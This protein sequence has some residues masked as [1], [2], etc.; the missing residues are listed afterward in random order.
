MCHMNK[1]PCF[2]QRSK[3]VLVVQSLCIIMLSKTGSKKFKSPK[4][5]RE[6]KSSSNLL[7]YSISE[8]NKEANKPA[9]L[10]EAHIQVV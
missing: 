1:L 10:R 6:E 9:W 8:K 3:G 7:A 2:V 4:T 5:A